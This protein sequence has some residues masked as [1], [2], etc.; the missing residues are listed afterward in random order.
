MRSFKK[1]LCQIHIH[2]KDQI[3]KTQKNIFHRYE[4]I[5]GFY[6]IYKSIDEE[7]WFFIRIC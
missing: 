6:L 7:T 4:K 5:S 2:P 1:C 3:R